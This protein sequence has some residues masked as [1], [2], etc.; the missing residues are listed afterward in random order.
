MLPFSTI[1]ALRNTWVY[2][3][4]PHYSDNTSNIKLPVN[5]FFSIVTILC[6]TDV[7]LDN[8]YVWLGR[9]F[10]NYWFWHKNN[11]IENMVVLENM[12]DI[13]RQDVCVWLIDKVRNAYDFDIK[14][15]LRKPRRCNAVVI[16]LKRIF[17]IFFNFLKVGTWSYAVSGNNNAFIIYTNEVSA[18][19]RLDALKSMI[20]VSNVSC[21]IFDKF[22]YQGHCSWK[23]WLA[24]KMGP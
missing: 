18:N 15:W 23:Q 14:L 20:D 9:D 8:S 19:I 22:F 10:I 16:G 7:N 21:W 5:D 1:F 17:Y 24:C 4:T 11:I 6:I 12:F 2:V 3:G 13:L